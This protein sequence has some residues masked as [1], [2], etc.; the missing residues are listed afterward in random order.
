MCV[1][2]NSRRQAD[3]AIAVH[4][5]NAPGSAYNYPNPSHGVYLHAPGE[6][7]PVHDLRLRVTGMQVAAAT[8]A[9]SGAALAVEDG[10]VHIP[11]LD[12]HEVVLLRV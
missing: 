12:L 9:L 4:L 7:V 6:V 3:G 8:L 5:H 11:R 10:T 1:T 2:V